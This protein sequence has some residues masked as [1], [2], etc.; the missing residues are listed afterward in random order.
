MDEREGPSP[1]FVTVYDCLGCKWLG[2]RLLKATRTG[3]PEYQND[4]NHPNEVQMRGS[5]EGRY[6]GTGTQTPTWCPV[7]QE[8]PL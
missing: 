1:R 2:R 4:C 6:I 8:G 7:L 3:K 5:R